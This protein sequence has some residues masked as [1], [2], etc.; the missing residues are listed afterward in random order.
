[1]MELVVALVAAVFGLAGTGVG[2]VL[3]ARAMKKGAV[4]SAQAT[5]QQVRG[6][7]TVDQAHWLRQQRLQ[8]YEGFLAAWDECLRLITSAG[9]PGDSGS[10]G[11]NPPKEAAD[12]MG[13]RARRIDILG[14]AEVAQAAEERAERIR[15]DVDMA[16]KLAGSTAPTAADRM[17][18]RTAPLAP[19]TAA[20][21][22]PAVLMPHD[23][24]QPLPPP[25]R[26][27]PTA[28]P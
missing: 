1:M 13:E 7:A 27:A 2:A 12:R 23:G 16:T 11:A 19:P 20:A 10:P 15:H 24:P 5:L 6:Q 25:S 8:A 3:S 14:P 9:L 22:M 26:T 28:G 18:N 17:A 21:P 4:L